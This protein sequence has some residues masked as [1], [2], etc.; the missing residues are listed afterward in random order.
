MAS[1]HMKPLIVIVDV[2]RDFCD[3]GALPARGTASLLGPLHICIEAARQ[4]GIQIAFTQDWHPSNHASFQQNG[5]RWPVHCVAGSAGAELAPP[6]TAGPSDIV[7]RNGTEP[8]SEGYSAFEGTDLAGT[9]H[10]LQINLVAVC[11][12]AT[13]YC[14][15]ATALDAINAGFT[16]SLLVDLVRPIREDDATIALAEMAKAGIALADS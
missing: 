4:R 7:V 12:I 16:T 2:Q 5:G 14:V 11:G 10:A 15:R 3:A 1:E 9:L 8:N 13:E 6:L